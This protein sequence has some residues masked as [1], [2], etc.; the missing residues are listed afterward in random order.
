MKTTMKPTERKIHLA[1]TDVFSPELGF[2]NY[3]YLT[4]SQGKGR[5][6]LST[7]TQH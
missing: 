3:D 4:V 6:N 1:I 5:G 2:A 7:Q